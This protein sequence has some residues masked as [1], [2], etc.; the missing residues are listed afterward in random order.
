MRTQKQA[1]QVFKISN[2]EGV[3]LLRSFPKFNAGYS[4][5][6]AQKNQPSTGT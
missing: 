4:Q 6:G 3:C 2:L 1:G 5:L